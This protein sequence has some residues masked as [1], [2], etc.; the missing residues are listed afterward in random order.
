MMFPMCVPETCNER[1]FQ[2]LCV[3]GEAQGGGLI[4]NAAAQT[5]ERKLTTTLPAAAAAAR[6]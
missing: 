6:S 5:R 3:L 2:V 4:R 1:P